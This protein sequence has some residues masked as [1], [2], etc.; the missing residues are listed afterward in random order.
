MVFSSPDRQCC[1]TGALQQPTDL[2]VNDKD[3]SGLM[4]QHALTRTLDFAANPNTTRVRLLVRDNA[5]GRMG[6]VDL[7][8]PSGP[9]TAATPGAPSLS[10]E[11]TPPK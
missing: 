9:V 7:P 4:A 1:L 6:S 2:T 3:Y 5:S 10:L 8:V 11:P